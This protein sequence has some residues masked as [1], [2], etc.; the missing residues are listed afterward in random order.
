MA[1]ST[2]QYNRILARLT[3]LEETMN[4]VL[5]AMEHYI[6]MSQMQQLLTIQKTELADLRSTVDSLEDRVEAIEEEPLSS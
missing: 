3:K 5:V 4:D 6:S 1:V 2:D